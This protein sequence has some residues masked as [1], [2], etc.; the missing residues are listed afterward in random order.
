MLHILNGDATAAVFADA[1]LSGDV[2][3]WCDILVEGPLTAGWT[4]P[5]ALASR[6]AYLAERFGIDAAQYVSGVHA[7][8]DGLASALKHDE[9]VLW[10][11]QDLF[12]AVNLWYVL[13]WFARRPAARLSLVYP[14]TDEVRG[15]G[16]RAPAELS[17]LYG[18]RRPVTTPMLALGRRAWE[19]YTDADPRV[20]GSLASGGS[21][22][23]RGSLASQ[24]SV[25]QRSS[26]P[27]ENA[28]LPFVRE[29]LRCHFGRFPS[30]GTGLNEVEA[31]TL[32]ALAGG[33][34]RFGDLFRA[35]TADEHGMGDVQLA[36]CV[37]GLA[38]LVN[39]SGGDV[40]S[41]EVAITALG[42]EVRT[43]RRDWLDVR[44][45]NVW[46]G[47]VHLEGARPRWRWDGARLVESPM[48]R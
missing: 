20:A 32:D 44:A 27:Q 16:V 29:A 41:A 13:A 11:E 19:A 37:R 43:G 12:C 33:A 24:S 40:M 8:E 35:V 14:P 25:S 45:I 7:Q 9:V 15:L 34:Q 1:K 46:L 4:K 10:F 2:L 31:A 5:A 3:V 23:S 17:A 21:P 6:A 36:A 39:L 22:V 48:S 18:E 26:V 38:P 42:R 30:V 47:G 28:A